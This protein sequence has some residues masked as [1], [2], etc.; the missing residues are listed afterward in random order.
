[1]GVV[2]RPEGRLRGLGAEGDS[3][4]A[5]GVLAKHASVGLLLTSE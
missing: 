5:L 1:M 2:Q 3:D 4:S